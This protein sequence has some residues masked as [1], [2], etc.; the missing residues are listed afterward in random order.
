[1]VLQADQGIDIQ[2]AT[3]IRFKNV[4]VISKDTNPVVDI[5]NSDNI[6]FD[7]LTYADQA[8][9]LFRVSGERSNKINISGTDAGKAKKKVSFELGA[10]E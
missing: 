9:L 8:Q 4:K 7:K 2:E 1:M 6:S 3:G 5:I 10:K